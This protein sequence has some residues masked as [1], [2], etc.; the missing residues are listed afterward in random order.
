MVGARERETRFLRWM[1]LNA[2][3]R[4]DLQFL[5]FIHADG[6]VYVC[7]C[8]CVTQSLPLSS[9]CTNVILSIIKVLQTGDRSAWL[10]PRT[11]ASATCE[12]PQIFF[13][14]FFRAL[15]V[16]PSL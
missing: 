8:V 10:L 11:G 3:S 14:F 9:H 1:E 12:T 16:I 15:Y 7:A 6:F 2:V 5:A 4:F 13:F